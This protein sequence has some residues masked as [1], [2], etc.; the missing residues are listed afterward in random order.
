[1]IKQ[2]HNGQLVSHGTFLTGMIIALAL[3][4][5]L[6]SCEP[7]PD[8][9]VVPDDLNAPGAIPAG[10]YTVYHYQQ[11]VSG[12]HENGD[13]TLITAD[14]DTDKV[15]DVVSSPA[16]LANEYAGFT[17]KSMMVNGTVIS[18][19]YD[20]NTITYTFNTGSQG[21]FSDGTT[22]KSV[23]GLYGTTFTIPFGVSSGSHCFVRW[24]SVDGT[25]T[26]DTDEFGSENVSWNAYYV[27]SGD[28]PANFVLVP[29][30]T[31]M[32]GREG[33]T[34]AI[35]HSVTLT[36][37]YYM[38]V[39]EVTAG[40]YFGENCTLGE[41]FDDN[42][43]GTEADRAVYNLSWYDAIVYCNKR[44]SAE[45][46]TPCYSINGETDPSVWITAAGGSV[47]SVFNESWNA[48]VC[49]WEANGYRLP[50]EAEWERAAR[51][52]NDSVSSY[53]YSGTEDSSALST[54]AWYSELGVSR[55]Q[56][57]RQKS[58][59]AFGLY[60]MSGNVWELC[61]DWYAL[62]TGDSE[63]NP[64]GSALTG[65][66]IVRGGCYNQPAS[67]A[68]VN[69]RIKEYPFRR[70]A[71]GSGNHFGLRVVRNVQ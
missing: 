65:Q 48:V 44:S 18:L 1:M 29:A 19:F 45:G 36:S 54:Y 58:P 46:L 51:A 24:I 50:T 47:P 13:Y 21:T 43:D 12:S 37:S 31:F 67:S 16:S 60:D 14:T 63:I 8:I 34:D 4:F 33:T 11:N 55:V 38:C 32:M 64:K 25:E 23:S 5:V 69:D 52:G 22:S 17:L 41:T 59:N 28:T 30:G 71:D 10:T 9:V 53:V 49:D 27:S 26:L 35:P 39:H 56:P 66:R 2:R 61:W 20:R 70:G 57:V 6:V 42:P 7:E 62:Y 15:L 68:S 40:E 3:A